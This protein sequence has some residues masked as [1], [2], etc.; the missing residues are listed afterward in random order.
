MKILNKKLSEE[1][2]LIVAV[3]ILG[4]LGA[5]ATVT[6]FL[7]QRGVWTGDLLI[8][9]QCSAYS[10]RGITVAEAAAA[11]L[12]EIGFKYIVA[13]VIMPWAAV[14][15]QLIFPGFLPYSVVKVWYY[16][17]LFF[18][19]IF[20]IWKLFH[21][22]KEQYGFEDE[23]FGLLAAISSVLMSWYWF[24]AINTG[25][26]G[27]LFGILGVLAF[28]YVREKPVIATILLTFSMC[29]PQIGGLFFLAFFLL[30]YYK[31]LFG[32]GGLL[33][34]SWILN[35]LYT[36]F[37][38]SVKHLPPLSSQGGGVVSALFFER[39]QTGTTQMTTDDFDSLYYG[40]FDPLR[41][42]GVPILAVMIMSAAAGVLFVLICFL[43]LRKTGEHIDPIVLCAVAALAS[44]FWAYKSQGDGV[45]IAVCNAFVILVYL[46]D[47]HKTRGKLF[48]VLAGLVLMNFK[49][50]KYFVRFA[51]G[52]PH[53]IGVT[54]DMLLQIVVFSC[55]FAI[56]VNSFQSKE[57][58]VRSDK[59]GEIL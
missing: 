21:Y 43:K 47:R 36:P 31:V 38:R 41:W 25:N 15:D 33:C 37:I 30:K 2:I 7:R 3:L 49:I 24:D 1:Q 59:A 34:S 5:A 27:S 48:C 44:L 56:Y 6:I 19:S 4:L 20:L 8:Y 57:C 11:P 32:C 23:R 35:S 51:F 45:V 39:I 10:V 22:F 13:N 28:F 42:L 55:F 53:T 52:L 58:E 18:A 46:W 16:S 40:L 50:I 12:P 9:W 14:F 54:G 26:P 29:K 17:C